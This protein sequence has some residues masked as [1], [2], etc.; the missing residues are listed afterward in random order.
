M[1]T[2]VTTTLRFTCTPLSYI[3][4]NFFALGGGQLHIDLETMAF[5]L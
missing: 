2:P 3:I 4:F 5:Y 1:P